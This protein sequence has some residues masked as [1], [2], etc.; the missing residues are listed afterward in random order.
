MSKDDAACHVS[1]ADDEELYVSRNDE[2]RKMM[3]HD[4]I[5]ALI[6]NAPAVMKRSL[7]QSTSRDAEPVR[8]L[9]PDPPG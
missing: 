5:V 8:A 7:I 4:V 1:C 9:Q 3:K 2:A 6:W